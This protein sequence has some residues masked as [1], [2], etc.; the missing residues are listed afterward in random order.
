MM[1]DEV[2]LA[3]IVTWIVG[4]VMYNIFSRVIYKENKESKFPVSQFDFLGDVILLP[5]FNALAASAGTLFL[6]FTPALD[7]FY[8]SLAT[9]IIITIGF[10]HFRKNL[11]KHNDWSR[12]RKGKFNAG[13][14]YHLTYIFLQTYF[15]AFTLLN[16]YHMI[17]LWIPIIGFVGLFLQRI[18]D[19]IT[20]KKKNSKK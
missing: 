16:F 2:L 8:Y 4:P 6:I 14:W 18:E 9:A 5:V 17:V 13:G 15:I 19:L 3:A 10:G 7:Y 1:G 11:A 12:P 20:D